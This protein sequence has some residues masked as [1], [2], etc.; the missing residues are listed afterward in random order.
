MIYKIINELLE[1]V[2]DI[3]IYIRAQQNVLI[4]SLPQNG[5]TQKKWV[6]CIL[7]ICTTEKE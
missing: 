3:Y 4:Q 1:M 2:K 6:L 7:L 5:N